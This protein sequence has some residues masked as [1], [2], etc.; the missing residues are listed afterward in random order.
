M[1]KREWQQQKAAMGMEKSVLKSE[2]DLDDVG[3]SHNDVNRTGT[4]FG[5]F[6]N[7]VCAVAGTG[8]LGL[9]YALKQGG[10]VALS[11]FFL[12]AAM[13]I[14]TS[15][16]LIEC[17][18]CKPGSRL[19]EFSD[20]GEAAFGKVGRYFVKVFQY[21][22]SLSLACIYILLAGLNIHRL[23]LE[24]AE[25]EIL[26]LKLLVVISGL[27]V[28][29]PFALLKSLKEV[30]ILSVFGALCTVV[31][32]IAV[33]VQ[34]AIDVGQS[35][36]PST[37]PY[38]LSGLPLS[39]STI[40]FS[41]TG[42][43]VFPHVEGT[44][45][46]PRSWNRVVT[47]S[48]VFVTALYIVTGVAGYACYGDNVMS[49][50]LNSLPKGVMSSMGYVLITLH[51]IL[52]APIYLCSF[53]LEQERWLGIDRSHMSASKEFLL[54]VLFR[55]SIVVILT[56]IA[57]FLPYFSDLMGLFGAVSGALVVFLIPVTCHYKL[58]GWR[59][60]TPLQHFGALVILT[61][62]VF[63]LVLGTS[64]SI[65]ALSDSIQKGDSTTAS[66]TH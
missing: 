1:Y 6:V 47:L 58:F 7:I 43:V 27:V 19:H 35:D 57:M 15:R 60:R 55:S 39:F 34:G 9:P 3:S 38:V 21:S 66:V 41:Y 45:K 14:Y 16:M 17:L 46:N 50:V 13:A 36:L 4:S 37:E 11:L 63:G 2:L 25:R 12:G 29:V 53:A 33:V 40:C 20:I 30:T 51:V 8:I 62:G 56:L 18:Y 10:W 42:N 23:I 54:R 31:V 49:P 28:M 59:H 5:T 22:A 52:A 48:I 44:M 64:S 32:V 24:Y 65:Q 26:S 61:V